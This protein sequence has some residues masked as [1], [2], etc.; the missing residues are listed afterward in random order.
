LKTYKI[1]REIIAGCK[2]GSPQTIIANENKTQNNL[3]LWN[4]IYTHGHLSIKSSRKKKRKKTKK[5]N[6]TKKTF[7][8]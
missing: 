7:Y 4:S 1:P 2:N 5:N 3:G 6:K 8:F